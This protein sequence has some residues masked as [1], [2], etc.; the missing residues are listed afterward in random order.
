MYR[1]ERARPEQ[2]HSIA[3]L[4]ALDMSGLGHDANPESYLPML[5]EALAAQGEGS[6]LWVAVPET[7]G[8]PVGVLFAEEIWS[9]KVA[10]KALWIEELF[11]HPE[12][13]RGGLG[14]QLVESLLD[15]AERAP[16]ILGVEL[17]AYQMN[18]AA[19]ILYRSLD[20]RRLARERYCFYFHEQ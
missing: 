5:R 19:S 9:L 16:E 2:I 15:W 20:F 18:T 10:G 8:Q 1:I 3:V 17:E 6:H 14:R 11:V 12:H 7:G 13:R 4:F